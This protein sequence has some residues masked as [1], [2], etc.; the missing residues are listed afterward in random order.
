MLVWLNPERH[1]ATARWM[2]TLHETLPREFPGVTFFFQPA[3]MVSQILN[4]GLPAPIDVQVTGYNQQATREVALEVA[5][6]MAR[7]PGAVDVHLHQV[8][9]AP[10]LLVNV[11]RSRAAETGLTQRDVANNL[12]VSLSSSAVV[13]PN[14]WSDPRTGIT[15]LVAVQ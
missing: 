1:A 5:A 2:M 7:I 6:R 13:S 15:Y 9:N 11:D 12:L 8:V 10:S 3:D 14:Y 4:F